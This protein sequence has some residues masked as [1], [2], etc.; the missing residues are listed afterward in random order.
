MRP[1][2]LN[3]GWIIDTEAMLNYAREHDIESELFDDEVS[4]DTC[5]QAL[6]AMV[7]H[8]GVPNDV[9]IR[10][11]FLSDGD[12]DPNAREPGKVNL[13]IG[14]RAGTNYEGHIADE[15]VDLLGS[16]VAPGVKP[17][18]FLDRDNW[19]WTRVK[20]KAPPPQS[21]S[22]CNVPCLLILT[23]HKTQR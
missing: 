5:M 11:V 7:D 18:W 19:Q 13:R 10:L 16:I 1:P 21:K 20:R 15:H 23:A 4:F 17:K 22:S 12:Y 2:V 9:R 6:G 14:V 3:L 8:N